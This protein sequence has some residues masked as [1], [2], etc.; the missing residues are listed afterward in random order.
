MDGRAI[1]M[2]VH[3]LRSPDGIAEHLLNELRF[4]VA[5]LIEQQ[6]AEIVDVQMAL[7]FV[8]RS[9]GGEVAVADELVERFEGQGQIARQRSV[10]DGATV[11]RALL[12]DKKKADLTVVRGGSGQATA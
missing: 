11:Y 4:S 6:A 8:L 3:C 12:P 2:L 5:D 1:K 7:W 9:A 10:V